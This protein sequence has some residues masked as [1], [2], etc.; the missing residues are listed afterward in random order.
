[1]DSLYRFTWLPAGALKSSAST[2]IVTF[3]VAD[4]GLPGIIEVLLVRGFIEGI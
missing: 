1:M 3:S 4:A 2:V